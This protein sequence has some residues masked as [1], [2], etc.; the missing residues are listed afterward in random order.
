MLWAAK[1]SHWK[2]QFIKYESHSRS[3]QIFSGAQAHQNDAA[4][5]HSFL[6]DKNKDAQNSNINVL[7]FPLFFKLIFKAQKGVSYE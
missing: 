4:P 7:D 1:N 6:P 2:L 5:Q 3:A